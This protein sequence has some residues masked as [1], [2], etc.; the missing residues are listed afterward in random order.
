MMND[1]NMASKGSDKSPFAPAEM[2]LSDMIGSNKTPHTHG[3]DENEG[4]F[5][6]V[7]VSDNLVFS[8]MKLDPLW[9]KDLQGSIIELLLSLKS[10]NGQ[11]QHQISHHL[12]IY[13]RNDYLHIFFTFLICFS[14][15]FLHISHLFFS[16]F[17]HVS[18]L[19]LLIIHRSVP[20]LDE[21]PLCER[22]TSRP[23]TRSFPLNNF[24]KLYTGQFFRGKR[25]KK[26]LLNNLKTLFK[27]K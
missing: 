5:L 7:N 13:S 19:F 25:K 20:V 8:P 12:A 15:H 21:R 14:P 22:S 2:Y 27:W 9:G 18:H 4:D 10:G 26:S 24:L 6:L 3:D 17:L 16:H 1:S 11:G 23:S